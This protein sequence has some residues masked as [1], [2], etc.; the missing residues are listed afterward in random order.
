MKRFMASMVETAVTHNK[1]Q[2][3]EKRAKINT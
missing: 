2:A 3:F 1:V